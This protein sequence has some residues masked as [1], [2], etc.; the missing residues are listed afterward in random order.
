MA[1]FSRSEL[2]DAVCENEVF[3]YSDYCIWTISKQ[4]KV[5]HAIQIQTGIMAVKDL[6]LPRLRSYWGGGD[7][8]AAIT[9][10]GVVVNQKWL[11][12]CSASP[13]DMSWNYLPPPESQ[14][15]IMGLSSL[16]ILLRTTGQGIC[17]KC[18]GYLN[19]MDAY[20]EKLK[21]WVGVD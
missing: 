5:M 15:E 6:G 18:W 11:D 12:W 9:L 4:S 17:K 3:K 20:H 14:V 16:A 7:Y 1:K 8:E 21:E 2:A 10:C 19:G 13:N